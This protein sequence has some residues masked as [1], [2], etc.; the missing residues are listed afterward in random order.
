ME[1]LQLHVAWDRKV[2]AGLRVVIANCWFV[3][4]TKI[5]YGLVFRVTVCNVGGNKRKT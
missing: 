3:Y 1:R 2:R 5:C 4:R